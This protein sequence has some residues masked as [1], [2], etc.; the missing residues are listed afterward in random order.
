MTRKQLMRIWPLIDKWLSG[1]ALQIR[2]D[3]KGFIYWDDLEED[4]LPV[5]NMAESP[6]DYRVKP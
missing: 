6:K 1:A 3:N 5:N 4:E 2:V